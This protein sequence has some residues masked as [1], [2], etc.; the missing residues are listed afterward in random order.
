MNHASGRG[1]G[2]NGRGR[3]GRGHSFHTGHSSMTTTKT[4]T[5]RKEMKDCK[6][7]L[8]G[9]AKSTYEFSEITRYL[10][11]YIGTTL[12]HGDEVETALEER[13]ELDFDAMMPV[14]KV[15]KSSDAATKIL[16]D[17][18]F[19]AVFKA[20]V[21]QHV[22]RED[23]YHA[24]MSKAYSLLWKQCTRELQDTIEGRSD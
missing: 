6:Y 5:K 20:K 3:S 18:S 12:T 24:N 13:K 4:D 23:A 7:T 19:E 1:R 22:K 15:S 11:N 14:K 21:Q 2:R 8:G 16:E 10:M 9:S 17:E